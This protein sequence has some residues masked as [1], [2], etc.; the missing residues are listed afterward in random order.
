MENTIA[1]AAAWNSG[2]SSESALLM[3]QIRN[4]SNAISG[5]VTAGFT[6]EDNLLG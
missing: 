5:A 6:S 1:L 4:T 3:E 2:L